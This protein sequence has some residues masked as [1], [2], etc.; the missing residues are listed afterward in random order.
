MPLAI[1]MRIGLGGNV[2]CRNPNDESMT[3]DEM[4]KGLF[5]LTRRCIIR[6]S[7]FRHSGFFRYS[8]F[9]VRH[10]GAVRR[11]AREKD[12]DF[13]QEMASAYAIDGRGCAIP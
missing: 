13:A 3:N 10:F 6:H 5:G 2:E 4:T 8:G 12:P 11:M 9:D 1:R 7:T